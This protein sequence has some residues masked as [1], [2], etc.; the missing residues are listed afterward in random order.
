MTGA[1]LK[2]WKNSTPETSLTSS[3]G[4]CTV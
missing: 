1:K 2:T 4:E 3:N